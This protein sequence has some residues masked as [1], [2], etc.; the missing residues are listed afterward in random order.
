[1]DSTVNSKSVIVVGAGIVGLTTACRLA[2]EGY[3]VHVIEQNDKPG[4]GTSKA[5]AGQLTFGWVSAMGSPGFLR[6]LPK[7]LF[8]PDQGISATGLFNPVK[9]PWAAAFARQCTA[10]AWRENTR[11][12]SELAH[13]SRE[14]MVRFN[15]RH[16][17]E[18]S[19]RKPGK[20]VL[21]QDA[22]SLAAAQKAA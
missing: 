4:E 13:R 5:N 7:S 2:E 19:W 12:L 14:A 15:Q 1:M 9:W 17:I 18:F 21:Y 10:P 11:G 3:K 16:K 6:S 22:T 20:I 8:D